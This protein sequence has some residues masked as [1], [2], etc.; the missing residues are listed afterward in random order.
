MREQIQPMQHP[1]HFTPSVPI[2]ERQSN[3]ITISGIWKEQAMIPKP[4]RLYRPKLKPATGA[5]HWSK[6]GLT[7]IFPKH[8]R[9][10][11]LAAVMKDPASLDVLKAVK[12]FEMR[13]DEALNLLGIEHE[14][15][16]DE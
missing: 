7:E 8:L 1:C 5:S 4:R 6:A 10:A 15:S 12:R 9:P 14:V 11:I 2:R 13:P 3:S 16:L